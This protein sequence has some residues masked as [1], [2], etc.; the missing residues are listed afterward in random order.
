MPAAS[1]SALTQVRGRRLAVRA[2]DADDPQLAARVAVERG[3]QARERQARVRHDNPGRLRRPAASGA[4]ETTAIG[5]ARERLRGERA[6]RRPSRP[7]SATNTVPGRRLARVVDDRL[8]RARRRRRRRARGAPSGQVAERARAGRPASW[9]LAPAF[10]AG[11][12]ARPAE[13]EPA[14]G[15]GLDRRPGRRAPARRRRRRRSRAAPRPSRARTRSASRP[16]RPR[17]SG[18]HELAVR[19]RTAAG[20]IVS[21]ADRARHADLARPCRAGRARAAPG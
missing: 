11:S 19:R 13:R 16:L 12:R 8:D 9:A 18:Q 6:C 21:G 14:G 15:A 2:G 3:G 17:R 4:R 7:C 20:T 1:N 10:A 5:A